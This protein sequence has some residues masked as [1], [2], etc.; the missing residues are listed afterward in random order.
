MPWRT[1][2]KPNLAWLCTAVVLSSTEGGRAA[3]PLFVPRVVDVRVERVSLGR[4]DVSM[5][6]AVRASRNVTIRTLRF[7]DGA[8]DKIPGWVTPIDGRR[9][10]RRGQDF[11]IP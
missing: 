5:Q 10:L 11:V 4:V 8:I 7:S 3:E 1:V 9:P 2:F 6:M